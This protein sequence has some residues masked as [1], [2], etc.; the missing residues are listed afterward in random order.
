MTEEAYTRNESEY[1]W[2]Y[3]PGEE[4]RNDVIRWRTF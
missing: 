1:P 2:E 3:E 4:G